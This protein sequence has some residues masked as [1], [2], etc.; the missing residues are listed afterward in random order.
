MAKQNLAA[1]ELQISLASRH[2]KVL[3]KQAWIACGQADA[4][5][6][7][8][9]LLLFMPLVDL[10]P[11]PAQALMWEGTDFQS[12]ASR[13]VRRL[14]CQTIT[15]ALQETRARTVA[16]FND[17]QKTVLKISVCARSFCH[18][19]G[20][21]VSMRLLLAVEVHCSS[22]KAGEWSCA[23]QKTVCRA[24]HSDFQCD[25]SA[26]TCCYRSENQV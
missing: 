9:P 7:G 12:S 26:S 20:L 3:T 21:C 15:E 17:M 2:A 25:S 11:R 1:T 13:T 16:K 5:K 4:A 23:I 18:C 10:F 14:Q 6:V 19:E 22:G 8:C 24:E